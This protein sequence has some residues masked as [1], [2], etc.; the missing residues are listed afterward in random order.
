MSMQRI[1]NTQ[2]KVVMCLLKYI[3]DKTSIIPSLYSLKNVNTE[4]LCCFLYSDHISF[5]L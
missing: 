3:Q 2:Y 4:S 5:I 1:F